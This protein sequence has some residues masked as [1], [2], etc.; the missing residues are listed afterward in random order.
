MRRIAISLL[1]LFGVFHLF[2]QTKLNIWEEHTKGVKVNIIPYLAE[3]KDN[4]SVIVCPGGSYFWH[5][6]KTEGHDVAHW[7]Q[8][9]GISAFVLDY[10]AAGWF[11]YATHFRL[12]SRGVRYPDA[13]ID[14]LQ[15]VRYIRLKAEE[16]GISSSRI[17]LMGFSAGGHLVMS[18]CVYFPQEDLPAFIVPVYPV[19]TMDEPY[20]H[21]RSRRA[22]LGDNEVGNEA[23]R[24]LMSLEKNIKDY[25]PPVFLVNCLDDPIVDYHNSIMLDSALTSKNINHIYLQYKNGGHGFGMSDKKGSQES[26]TW[27]YLFL[28]WLNDLKL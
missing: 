21:K 26:R 22:L 28:K 18:S 5:D 8:S 13:Q 11:A 19:V 20:V 7:L 23:K 15:A 12:F 6:M 16:F 4:I 2:A 10:R 27:K 17:G 9:K 1:L 14:L 3:G 24:K 25:C